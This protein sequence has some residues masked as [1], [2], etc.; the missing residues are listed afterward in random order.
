MYGDVASRRYQFVQ[1]GGPNGSRLGK[2]G[3]RG[4]FQVGIGGAYLLG[5]GGCGSA[6]LK[7]FYPKRGCGP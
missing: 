1:F 7:G 2:F 4:K 5:H 3:G 6:G